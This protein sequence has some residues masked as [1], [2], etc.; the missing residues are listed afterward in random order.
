MSA[1]DL[2]CCTSWLP[3]ALFMAC[4]IALPDSDL[5]V[6]IL[7]FGANTASSE[8]GIY[9]M[10]T[11]A[12]IGLG[13]TDQGTSTHALHFYAI[14]EL[15]PLDDGI[16]ALPMLIVAGK[17]NIHVRC[18][19]PQGHPHLSKTPLPSASKHVIVQGTILR[20]ENEHCVL[21]V[22]DIAFGPSDN[23]VAGPTSDVISSTPSKG[24]DWS[25][26]KKRNT[27]SKDGTDEK[28]KE[29]TKRTQ[30]DDKEHDIILC[31][32]LKL[33]GVDYLACE[34]QRQRHKEKNASDELTG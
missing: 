15:Q 26:K 31:Q 8:D 11:Q 12:M 20:I 22:K 1:V 25:G 13:L 24:F 3:L 17:Q 32:P 19:Y 16:H 14:D 23:V 5:A 2:C 4:Y 34:A 10:H 6:S 29:K 18:Y 30:E 9:L 27:K 33:C 21:T 7:T 28:G